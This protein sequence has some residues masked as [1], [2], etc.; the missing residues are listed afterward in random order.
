MDNESV[1]AA[2]TLVIRR[3]NELLNDAGLPFPE[4]TDLRKGVLA[5]QVLAARKSRRAGDRAAGR[6]VG[7]LT[8]P[9]TW[10]PRSSTPASRWSGRGTT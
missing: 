4:G 2:S 6:A 3:L 8:T 5:K 9:R 10:S 1:G 7:A